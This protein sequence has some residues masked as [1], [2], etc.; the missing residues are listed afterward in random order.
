MQLDIRHPAPIIAVLGLVIGP[1]LINIPI[2]VSGWCV[3]FWIYTLLVYQRK[4]PQPGRKIRLIYTVTGCMLILIFLGG[5]TLDSQAFIGLLCVMAGLKPLEATR[6]RDR[7][8]TL[9]MAYFIIIISLFSIENLVI[10]LYMFIAVL[11]TTTC[12]VHINHPGRQLRVNLRLVGIIMLQAMPLMVLLFILF[13]RL[14]GS[15]FSLP[16]R[17]AGQTGFTDTLRP[18][19]ISQ[20]VQVD[21]TAFRVQFDQE[22]P[23]AA[24]LYWRGLVLW[25]FDGKHW[26]QGSMPRHNKHFI[27]SDNFVEYDVILEPHRKQH[28]FA[29]D[30]PITAPRFTALTEDFTLRTRWP[31][32][33]VQRYH[34]RS[35]QDVHVQSG[36]AQKLMAR[37]LPEEGNPKSRFLAEAWSSRLGSPQAVLNEAVRYFSQGDFVYTLRPGL[38]GENPVDGFLFNTRSG[39]CEH[40]AS[41]FA[42]LMRAA[43]IPARVVVG[44]LGGDLN[45]YGNYLIVKQYHAHAWVEVFIDDQGWIRVD[46]TALVA[47][48][49]VSMG[50]TGSL[51]TDDLPDFL[52]QTGTRQLR[53][54]FH[55]LVY[56]MDAI[57]LRWNSIFM[58]YSR[59]EQAG[60]LRKVFGN[61]SQNRWIWIVALISSVVTVVVWVRFRYYFRPRSYRK[62]QI[63]ETYQVFCRKLA[64]IG[65]EKHPAQGPL[66]FANMINMHRPELK[67]RVATIMD[68][69]IAL[70]YRR[71]RGNMSFRMFK[72]LVRRFDGLP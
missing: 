24:D 31:V 66:D 11:A 9:F 64:G 33:T 1:L 43:G 35:A 67:K 71:A 17:F 65:I 5:M 61:I 57:N 36:A 52:N 53:A 23:E 70:R 8:V 34:L 56:I 48:E 72:Q 29:L 60:L 25:Y 14:E 39:Y 18:G 44:F 51:A 40:Y 47:P 28:L 68:A 62:D 54:Y 19:S 15:I 20:L 38:L 26:T 13:P 16:G 59:L 22:I 32:R 6:H 69:Y 63:Q 4:L 2:W 58:E 42:Y 30:V 41:A 10:S 55:R 7:V 3:V 50:I 37:Q 49:R 12:L 21:Q 27:R 45:P 46:P